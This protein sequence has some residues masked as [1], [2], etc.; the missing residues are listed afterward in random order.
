MLQLPARLVEKRVVRFAG[1]AS[2]QLLCEDDD[3]KRSRCAAHCNYI[4]TVCSHCIVLPL[5]TAPLVSQQVHTLG[6]QRPEADKDG[7]RS[8][9]K[10]SSRPSLFPDNVKNPGFS[11]N[12]RPPNSGF[13]SLHKNVCG[14]IG[15]GNFDW[16][17]G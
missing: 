14:Q 4:V 15:I 12:F 10:L 6:F 17:N 5:L 11:E 9:A 7:G 13:E 16:S 8:C 1:A 3:L 2:V